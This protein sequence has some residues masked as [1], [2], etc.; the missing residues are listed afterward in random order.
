MEHANFIEK[1]DDKYPWPSFA[2]AHLMLHCFGLFVNTELTSSDCTLDL[3]Q[4]SDQFDHQL[5]LGH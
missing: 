2:H 4:D 1:L 5:I 3:D